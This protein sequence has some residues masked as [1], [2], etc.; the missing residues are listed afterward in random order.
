MKILMHSYGYCRAIKKLRLCASNS[1]IVEI[2]WIAICSVEFD[3]QQK[4]RIC[5]TSF[6]RVLII[7]NSSAFYPQ[8]QKT[9]SSLLTYCCSTN[10]IRFLY[11]DKFREDIIQTLLMMNVMNLVYTTNLQFFGIHCFPYRVY[12]TAVFMTRSFR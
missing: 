6:H 1:S 2:H 3:I 12:T 8:I 9:Q 11:V 4:W 5:Q 10:A 7:D